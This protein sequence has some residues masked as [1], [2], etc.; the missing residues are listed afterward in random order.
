[1]TDRLDV[2]NVLLILGIV[3]KFSVMDLGM[4]NAVYWNQPDNM[5]FDLPVCLYVQLLKIVKK[6]GYTLVVIPP[7]DFL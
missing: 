7:T 2:L 5:T 4:P 3:S 1:M 6:Q